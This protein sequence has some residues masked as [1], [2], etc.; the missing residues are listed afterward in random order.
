MVNRFEIF[1]KRLG[2]TP[3][4][5]LAYLFLPFYH[6][7]NT[8][9][10]M[11]V[12]GYG[13]LLLF[14]IAYIKLYKVETV[15]QTFL[16]IIVIVS[17]VVFFTIFFSPYNIMLGFYASNFIGWLQSKRMFTVAVSLFATIL[18]LC[19]VWIVV[20]QGFGEL[21]FLLPFLV[22]MILSPYG[23]RSMMHRS[24]LEEQLNEANEKISVLIKQEERLRIAR[25]LHDTLGHTLS[26]ITLQSQV[27]QRVATMPEK[28]LEGAKEIEKTSRSA[29]KQVRDLVSNMRISSIEEELAHMAQIME[30]GNVT[31]LCTLPEDIPELT[32][33]QQNIIGLCIREAST[34]LI[35]HSEAQ[36][37]FVRIDHKESEFQL[38]IKDNGIGF[39]SKQWGNGLKGM[40]E[41]LS[42]IEGK[43]TV[44]SD[45]GTALHISIPIVVKEKEGAVVL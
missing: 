35:K 6:V 5:F 23:I 30:A 45:G 9:G 42:L 13:A 17:L 33:L 8:D 19:T 28:V 10:S 44:K 32:A 16:W 4:I 20:D 2:V 22:V 36:K 34:N 15:K 41:R 1:P 26:L 14:L 37:C 12:M 25:D 31:L 18:M 7:L 39:Q 38:E 24:E 29:M 27:I 21:L 3:Y 11:A 43:F 40:A